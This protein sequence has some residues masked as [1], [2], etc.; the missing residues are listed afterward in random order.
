MS[1]KWLHGCNLKTVW[2]QKSRSCER[3]NILHQ[4]CLKHGLA[5]L[6]DMLC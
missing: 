2:K 4:Q 3:L 1:E 6:I 5:E